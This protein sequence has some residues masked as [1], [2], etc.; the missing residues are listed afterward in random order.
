MK[1]IVFFL[2]IAVL[3]SLYS[4]RKD[5]FEPNQPKSMEELTVPANFDWK[6]TKDY[7]FTL[8]AASAGIVTV[9]SIAGATYHRAFLVQGSPYTIK[10]TLPT[11]EKKVSLVFK[12]QTI[13]VDLTSTTISRQ[14]N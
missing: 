12:G 13:E 2:M 9:N 1:K 5:R 11:Y 6:T 10:L 14:F 4:C 7:T 8:Q 3:A